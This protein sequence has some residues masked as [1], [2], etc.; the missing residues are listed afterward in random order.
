MSVSTNPDRVYVNR[1]HRAKIRLDQG[2]TRPSA[3]LPGAGASLVDISPGGCCL[4]LIRSEVPDGVAPGSFLASIK[5]LHPD[6]D[7]T[8][9]E[10]RIAWSREEPPSVLVGI[11]FTHVRPTTAVSIQTYVDGNRSG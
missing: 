1:Q 6:L 11:Q 9:I 8:P 2:E 4:R 10:G 3:S 7:S 5:L